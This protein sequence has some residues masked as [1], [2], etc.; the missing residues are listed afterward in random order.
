MTSHHL[1][2]QEVEIARYRFLEK[3]VT[4]PLAAS[5]LHCI[6][7]DLEAHLARSPSCGDPNRSKGHR[8]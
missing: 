8:S 2:L 3:A 4:D 7:E 5:L 6:I 1:R